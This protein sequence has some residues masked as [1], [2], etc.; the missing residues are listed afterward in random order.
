[1]MAV[2]GRL[3]RSARCLFYQPIFQG[4]GDRFRLRV[5][6]KFLVNMSHMKLYGVVADSEFLCC[7]GVVVSLHQKLEQP[8]LMRREFI[9]GTFRRP[10]IT[11]QLDNAARHFRGPV[12]TTPC[13]L[14]QA[15]PPL[16][17]GSSFRQGT[18]R[19]GAEW[20]KDP[21]VIIVNGEYQE[22]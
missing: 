11:E 10:N 20:V 9:D 1:M 19:A 3:H 12:R 7:R 14:P 6:L 15:L 13:R 8:V 4:L 21:I 17:G 18:A 16:G 5:H 2:I 22:L